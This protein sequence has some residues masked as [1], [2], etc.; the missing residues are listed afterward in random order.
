MTEP[1][2]KQVSYLEIE[3]M[4]ALQELSKHPVDSEEYAKILRT[5]SE[6]E[7]I[8]QFEADL[9]E[10]PEK[11]D[12]ISKDTMLVVGANLLGILMVISYERTHVLNSRAMQMLTRPRQ[13]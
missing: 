9:K 11:P 4:R 7:K 3:L 8:K 5:V 1:K 2:V 10:K 12:R 13:V 6:L